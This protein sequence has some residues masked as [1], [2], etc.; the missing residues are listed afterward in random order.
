M[1]HEGRVSLGLFQATAD[2]EFSHVRY[3]C[4]FGGGASDETKKHEVIHFCHGPG[5]SSVAAIL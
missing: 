1:R 4:F 3:M 5:N 2:N